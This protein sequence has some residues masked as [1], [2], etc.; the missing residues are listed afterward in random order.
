MYY[1]FVIA[2]LILNVF[3]FFSYAQ[4][5]NL[6][7]DA[8][9]NCIVTQ[10]TGLI[11]DEDNL[12]FLTFSDLISSLTNDG[13]AIGCVNGI[14]YSLAIFFDSRFD[15]D[16]SDYTFPISFLFFDEKIILKSYTLSTWYQST[17]AFLNNITYDS[18]VKTNLLSAQ[19][20]QTQDF[21]Q[22]ALELANLQTSLA[23]AV[24]KKQKLHITNLIKAR[25]ELMLS[26]DE[27]Y[28]L[29][30]VS[31]D[32][33]ISWREA[34]V[35]RP[36]IVWQFVNVVLDG[37]SDNQ[38]LFSSGVLIDHSVE[39]YNTIIQ[40]YTDTVV[41]EMYNKRPW[42]SFVMKTTDIYNV[43][44]LQSFVI[45]DVA[46]LEVVDTNFID[47]GSFQASQHRNLIK[48]S[49]IILV[50]NYNDGTGALISS[51]LGSLINSTPSVETNAQDVTDFLSENLVV[52]AFQISNIANYNG[53]RVEIT[54][55][56]VVLSIFPVG[57][58]L[59]QCDNQTYITQGSS[60]FYSLYT[61]FTP[62]IK[63]KYDN[64][65]IVQ[66]LWHEFLW[67]WKPV[68]QTGAL[69]TI[70]CD[71]YSLSPTEFME[72]QGVGLEIE[73]FTLVA[74]YYSNDTTL[75]PINPGYF[76]LPQWGSTTH[77][78]WCVVNKITD[79]QTQLDTCIFDTVVLMA[80]PHG[81]TY[82]LNNI[83]FSVDN[84][85][86][87]SF[88]N[89]KIQ[90]Y[91]H[92]IGA[93][94]VVIQGITFIQPNNFKEEVAIFQVANS[95]VVTGSITFLNT[96]FQGCLTC[97][98]SPALNLQDC[99]QLNLYYNQFENF[100]SVAINY[101][102]SGILSAKLLQIQNEFQSNSVTTVYAGFVTEFVI[103][104]NIVVN[105]FVPIAGKVGTLDDNAWL[106][107]EV[108]DANLPLLGDWIIS[109]NVQ[110][111][112]SETVCSNEFSSYAML[113]IQMLQTS[114]EYIAMNGAIMSENV[115]VNSLQGLVLVYADVFDTLLI[116]YDIIWQ[117]M[118]DNTRLLG[119]GSFCSFQPEA[120]DLLD[121]A[122][123]LYDNNVTYYSDMTLY[124][125]D[126]TTIESKVFP[127]I[128]DTLWSSNRT[129]T[130]WI[131]NWFPLED[132]NNQIYPAEQSDPLLTNITELNREYRFEN[133]SFALWFCPQVVQIRVNNS[134]TQGFLT[135][136]PNSGSLFW[137]RFNWTLTSNTDSQ[138]GILYSTFSLTEL[139]ARNSS[140]N[141]SLMTIVSGD[142]LDVNSS[143]QQPPELVVW[144]DY[145]PLYSFT[146][147]SMTFIGDWKFDEILDKTLLLNGLVINNSTFIT[148][149]T[150]RDFNTTELV[151]RN[152]PQ[153][154]IN[155]LTFWPEEFTELE[156]LEK[157]LVFTSNQIWNGGIDGIDQDQEMLPFLY[158]EEVLTWEIINNLFVGSFVELGN[159]LIRV[160]TV[161]SRLSSV[162]LDV[163]TDNSLVYV[164]AD[165]RFERD[166]SFST[167]STNITEYGQVNMA[168]WLEGPFSNYS[169]KVNTWIFRN[170]SM[171][172]NLMYG[173][174]A[175][176]TGMNDDVLTLNTTGTFISNPLTVLA[177]DDNCNVW[178]SWHDFIW[179]PTGLI[180]TYHYRSR[181]TGYADETLRICDGNF[182]TFDPY[183]YDLD[184]CKCPTE[185]PSL[186]IVDSD[187]VL[188]QS[189]SNHPYVNK[190]WFPTIKQALL[191]CIASSRTILI[192]KASQPYDESLVFSSPNWNL[193]SEDG[194][195]IQIQY[196]Q[197]AHLISSDNIGFKGLT[198]SSNVLPS[199]SYE[200]VNSMVGNTHS[201]SSGDY[202]RSIFTTPS[203]DKTFVV[204]NI[205][206]DNCTF[207]LKQE[208]GVSAIT[209]DWKSLYIKNSNFLISP[210]SFTTLDEWNGWSSMTKSERNAMK[211]FYESKQ[212]QYESQIQ[213]VLQNY[214]QTA[215][216][217]ELTLQ[218]IVE[219]VKTE[220]TQSN[221]QWIRSD[222]VP[223]KSTIQV[224]VQQDF[225]FDNNLVLGFPLLALNITGS[226]N[227]SVAIN[228]NHLLRDNTVNINF[229]NK[230]V[231]Q[232]LQN[233]A[234]G[235]SIEAGKQLNLTGNSFNG[236]DRN[237][238]ANISSFQSEKQTEM[239]MFSLSKLVFQSLTDN[240]PN[241]I[242]TMSLQKPSLP[243]HNYYSAVWLKNV[244]SSLVSNYL[245]K[246]NNFSSV[247]L[248][249]RVSEY[250]HANDSAITKQF[251]WYNYEALVQSNPGINGWWH[252][253]AA[254]DPMYDYD[255]AVN[256]VIWEN[257]VCDGPCTATQWYILIGLG[258]GIGVFSCIV[259]CIIGWGVQRPTMRW[260][261]SDVLQRRIPQDQALRPQATYGILP[262]F[263]DHTPRALPQWMTDRGTRNAVMDRETQIQAIRQHKLMTKRAKRAR[264]T[265]LI[266]KVNEL[267]AKVDKRGDDEMEE[268]P[269]EFE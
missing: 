196:N 161:G 184:S 145:F 31:F 26:I 109:N 96:H 38:S 74:S 234:S 21:M 70:W 47:S 4:S 212:F 238:V 199:Y 157:V 245:I 182:T 162:A 247:P 86:L 222:R 188:F 244:N 198:F 51:G 95:F 24:S 54:G 149:D 165:N 186:C 200:T 193:I 36:V 64:D 56:E 136:E 28:N 237:L 87:L 189:G 254:I 246:N 25:N 231:S 167:Y 144:W 153:A 89:A 178:G 10:D 266:K 203:L 264:E 142:T 73:W 57:I 82:A 262:W 204:Q 128:N 59:H 78:P 68:Y 65:G 126:L 260:I 61:P 1:R 37:N 50:D 9:Q 250:K 34:E 39:F 113:L 135:P 23:N 181:I 111:P 69:Q 33:G 5:I 66:G 256:P 14:D 249:L 129:I 99:P 117:L 197:H 210:S 119:Y 102:N 236:F 232:I 171:E 214:Q 120:L 217:S 6:E 112:N 252:D 121:W 239:A 166:S 261:W 85:R 30:T 134:A 174:G 235:I 8:L 101:A 118:R 131:D 55:N 63:L 192:M 79:L 224:H 42:S 255:A 141:L 67:T 159:T 100:Y 194:A 173:A 15:Y 206:F 58:W 268:N 179:I 46:N 176:L 248:G 7:G 240:S 20:W 22:P 137:W 269:E 13:T 41:L 160:G 2:I 227:H 75:I 92:N 53:N 152:D 125:F 132:I 98:S 3:L 242:Q 72:C 97:A 267:E 147:E 215:S 90:G 40:N 17:N 49:R 62:L 130:C 44:N 140:I 88:T 208:S 265:A 163:I 150:N 190:W 221:R 258:L 219:L 207:K 158:V 81:R 191:A 77:D 76:I 223:D 257:F 172:D 18:S 251:S 139:W 220:Q 168:I 180:N 48:E 229:D 177:S 122:V 201:K 71:T 108:D 107:L 84:R 16:T 106:F 243:V 105:P 211:G 127:S 155:T 154:V 12:Y 170:V 241:P 195:E 218:G 263:R 169:D 11:D 104:G 83:A 45:H 175:K 216:S 114:L 233:G 202:S 226:G 35:E 185:L 110:I 230:T 148:R 116:N 43:I 156:A 213:Q 91:G 225:V 124:S 52:A 29:G 60:E 228:R 32:G 133:L 164:F 151:V 103:L 146:A 80:D 259:C 115:S 209:G 253:L 27:S 123:V 143:L 187:N 19:S 183:D 205:T 138:P 94:N 93:Q